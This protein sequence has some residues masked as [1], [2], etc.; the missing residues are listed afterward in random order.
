VNPRTLSTVL[1]GAALG[2]GCSGS[3]SPVDNGSAPGATGTP[4][5]DAASTSSSDD[6]TTAP[7]SSSP[8][9]S[10]T[11]AP[12]DAGTTG[13]K[14]SGPTAPVDLDAGTVLDLDAGTCA[15]PS[16]LDTN[17]M[18]A[19]ALLN[20]TRAA[21]GSPCATMVATLDTSAA[22]HCAYYAANQKADAGCIADPHVEVAGCTDYVGAQFSMR[23]KSAGYTGQPSFEVMAFSDNGTS[24]VQQWIDSVWHRTPVLSPWTR[25][26]GY[27]SATKCDTIDFGVGA[28]APNN[29][30]VAYPYDGE[31]GVPTLFHGN[32]E[33]PVPPVPPAGWPSGY[34]VHVYAKGATIT[35]H[36]FSAEGGPLLDHQWITP[37]INSLA[38]NAVILYGN[39]PLTAATK[40]HVHVAGTGMG[41]VPLD[42]NITFTTK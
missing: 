10:S 22:D 3:S 20:G 9:A 27:G 6:A 19:L 7:S 34:P 12:P 26:F 36:E 30:V 23:E 32:E 5:N 17:S 16:G 35:T 33:G 42:V 29:L 38:Q 4:E 37:A 13:A 28:S 11:T 1:L 24:S 21:M 39:V 40:Y 25:D 31:T 2:A 15:S 14:D 18:E 8:D 41:G